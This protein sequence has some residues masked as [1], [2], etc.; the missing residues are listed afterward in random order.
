MWGVK[1]VTTNPDVRV[2]KHTAVVNGNGEEEPRYQ[3]G[4][5]KK[6]TVGGGGCASEG[7]VLSK[8]A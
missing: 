5:V 6:E 3:I 8:H 4:D 1:E 7:G 2:L